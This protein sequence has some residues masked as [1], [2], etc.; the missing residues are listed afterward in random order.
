M[1]SYVYMLL[2]VKFA[3]TA[4]F[5]TQLLLTDISISVKLAVPISSDNRGCTIFRTLYYKRYSWDITIGITQCKSSKDN[6]FVYVM[7]A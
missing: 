7:Y 6:K 2:Y 3:S 5:Y 1:L 4:N